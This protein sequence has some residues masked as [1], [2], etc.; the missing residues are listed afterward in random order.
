MVWQRLKDRVVKQSLYGSA[1]YW[2]Q[3][4]ATMEGL[5]KSLWPNNT[6][7]RE[8][9]RRCREVF[10]AYLPLPPARVADL[11][12]GSGRL[13]PWLAAEG[14]DWVGA[15]FSAHALQAARRELARA[16]IAKP[17]LVQMDIRQMPF[18]S[19]YFDAVIV[20]GV[21]A[22]ACPGSA[23]VDAA[24][25]ELYR[26]LAQGGRALLLE[27]FHRS[28]MFR[29]LNTMNLSSWCDAARA[30]GFDIVAT[31][32]INFLPMR[33]GLAQWPHLAEPIVEQG[34]RAGEWLLEH[35][36]PTLFSDYKLL[37]LKKPQ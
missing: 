37:V 27:P 26:V 18:A 5:A 32:G 21:Y 35:T 12:C 29:R 22:M 25:S 33:F 23:G 2:D 19:D 17:A 11:G 30:A 7:N 31:S 16:S 20:V 3:R 8:M 13:L 9:D 14:Y 1:H 24:L 34:Y 15:D 36:S 10:K 28:R 6:Y 4:A